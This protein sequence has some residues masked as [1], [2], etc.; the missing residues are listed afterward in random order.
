VGTDFHTRIEG[1]RIKHHMGRVAL[2]MYDKFGQALRIETVAND[3]SFFKHHRTVEHRDGSSSRKLAAVK[4]TI[5]SLAPLRDLLQASNRRYLDFISAFEDSSSGTDDLDKIAQRV[6]KPDRSYSGFNLLESQDLRLF[7]A[8]T[9]GEFTSAVSTTVPFAGCCPATRPLNLAASSS[10]C[11][12][13][14]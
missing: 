12:H 2:K 3:V 6:H 7:L 1:T 5:Y 10:A 11:A 8:L 4:K 9:H 14:A 13:T